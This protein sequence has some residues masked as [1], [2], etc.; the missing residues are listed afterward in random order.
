[1]D[2]PENLGISQKQSRMKAASCRLS[3]VPNTGQQICSPVG[4]ITR[5][6]PGLLQPTAGGMEGAK[7][8]LD[9]QYS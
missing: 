6:G 3:F 9:Y 1:M 7:A 8:C 2:L 5:R 4:R